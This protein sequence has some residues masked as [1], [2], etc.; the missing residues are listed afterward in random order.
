MS[1]P[2]R[3]ANWNLA[4]A[5]AF[6]A[7]VAVFLVF[8]KRYGPGYTIRNFIRGL[9]P[10]RDRSRETKASSVPVFM[11]TGLP[12]T[13][14]L[15]QRRG[16]KLKKPKRQRTG[17]SSTTTNSCMMAGAVF[18]PDQTQSQGQTQPIQEPAPA[19]YSRPLS[20]V[21]TDSNH[22][23]IPSVTTW[24]SYLYLYPNTPPP[25]QRQQEHDNYNH[26]PNS[27]KAIVTTSRRKQPPSPLCSMSPDTRIA[28][29][30]HLRVL[31][32]TSPCS[33]RSHF[34]TTTQSSGP[35]PSSYPMGI[36][37]DPSRTSTTT[38]SGYGDCRWSY[39]RNYYNNNHATHSV[40]GSEDHVVSLP[41]PSPMLGN[42][43]RPPGASAPPAYSHVYQMMRQSSNGEQQTQSQRQSQCWEMDSY[44]RQQEDEG[45]RPS[46]YGMT[47]HVDDNGLPILPRSVFA[48]DSIQHR[49]CS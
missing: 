36:G 31:T 44:H 35:L 12:R 6:T 47:G 23:S 25:Q 49:Q 9:R 17:R 21:P 16:T 7:L 42:I 5:I 24:S 32:P 22:L 3:E 37:R 15:P 14:A 34:T 40:I 30:N 43:I 20:A 48:P 41:S 13:D 4:V 19:R 38:A 2:R 45:P 46:R 26:N 39:C 18:S 27:N 29:D 1:C 11:D 33:N 8:R 28:T 10:E